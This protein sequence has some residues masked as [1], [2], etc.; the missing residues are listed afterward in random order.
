MANIADLIQ[1]ARTIRIETK[2]KKNTADRIGGLLLDIVNGLVEA[3]SLKAAQYGGIVATSADV[4]SDYAAKGYSGPYF[5]LV[6]ASLSSLVVYQY[7]GSGSPAQAFGGAAYDFADYS[8]AISRLNQLDSNIDQIEEQINE[9]EQ[10]YTEGYLTPSAV[11]VENSN[12]ALSDFIEVNEGDRYDWI[13]GN[14]TS[15]SIFSVIGY[16]END[17]WMRVTS[18]NKSYTNRTG[19]IPEGVVKIR[20]SVNKDFEGAG[21]KVNNQYI[22]RPT[23]VDK[24]YGKRLTTLE[25]G[26]QS[27]D[28][29]I[30]TLK[31]DNQT[32]HSIVDY[33]EVREEITLSGT[34]YYGVA[35]KTAIVTDLSS[36]IAEPTQSANYKSAVIDCQHGDSF[37]LSFYHGTAASW[38]IVDD[39]NHLLAVDN[40]ERAEV[41]NDV[42]ITVPNRAAKLYFQTY[43][44]STLHPSYFIAGDHSLP[45]K[46]E[47][48]EEVIS[49]IIVTRIDE[50]VRVKT[51]DYTTKRVC[52]AQFSDTHNNADGVDVILG[53]LAKH[54]Q[55]ISDIIMT[56]DLGNAWDNS[57]AWWTQRDTSGILFCIG[58]HEIQTYIDGVLTRVEKTSRIGLDAYNKFIAPFVSNW[59]VV[60][61]TDAATYGYCF[62]YKDYNEAIRL[63]VLDAYNYNTPQKT[64]MQ[65]VLADAITNNLQ[66]VV[67]AHQPSSSFHRHHTN[68]DA[69]DADVQTDVWLSVLPEYDA[70][71]DIQDF[72]DNGGQFVCW[73]T[74]HAHRDH[75]GYVDEYPSQTVVT[76][77]TA[78]ADYDGSDLY[79]G[80]ENVANLISIDPIVKYLYINRLGAN[81]DF[82]GRSRSAI[83]WDYAHNKVV[84]EV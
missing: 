45:K 54:S 18:N 76:I 42:S 31:E 46:I 5:Y 84:S 10:N 24:S 41:H 55:Y 70:H 39:T 59:D 37:I 51:N 36:K 4:V 74:G 13:Y 20:I 71:E 63:I 6:G 28:A 1:R 61:P 67:M 21:F 22:W 43:S 69:M 83:V 68:F 81:M 15:N 27:L 3:Q 34:F 79:R 53:Y 77:D 75:F 35:L 16:Y 17:D 25:G 23:L 64:W 65:G 48:I 66:V 40:S 33:Q 80:G 47:E 2:S 52:F 57:I 14:T 19:T 7:A 56:G 72:I 30:E 58:N 78:K 38:F 9:V 11:F 29:E 44:R 8:E 32:L 12:R 26:V 82:Y 49:S 60:Q 62:Y 73:I 50:N